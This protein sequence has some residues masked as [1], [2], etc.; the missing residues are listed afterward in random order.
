MPYFSI[1]TAGGPLRGTSC[2]ANRFIITF[3]TSD[4]APAT[5][6]PIPPKK[7]FRINNYCIISMNRLPSG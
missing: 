4:N 6:S 5:A 2:T 3:G 7:L 1:N